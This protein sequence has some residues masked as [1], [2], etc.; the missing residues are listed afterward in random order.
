MPFVP[1]A[2][3]PVPVSLPGE[4]DVLLPP[5][6]ELFVP[7]GLDGV[8]SGGVLS[9]FVVFALPDFEWCDFLCVLWPLLVELSDELLLVEV[10]ESSLY[11]V[12]VCATTI[13]AALA[14]CA[15]AI[16]VYIKG[17]ARSADHPV[18]TIDL[19]ILLRMGSPF[20]RFVRTLV[21]PDKNRIEAC[22][23]L[24]CIV[25]RRE[26]FSVSYAFQAQ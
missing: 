24:L 7:A 25:S 14:G 13:R 22:I 16:G 2:P 12:S 17:N 23:S 26:G 20:C 5:V 6:V 11:P 15:C 4:T 10:E 8:I 21:L 18:N 1:G 19:R 3:V 9:G